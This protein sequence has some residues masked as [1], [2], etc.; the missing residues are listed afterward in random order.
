MNIREQ[1]NRDRWKPFRKTTDAVRFGHDRPSIERE[2][3]FWESTVQSKA[4]PECIKC[5]SLKAPLLFSYN[6]MYNRE[7]EDPTAEKNR[8]S[9]DP[10]VP[11]NVKIGTGADIV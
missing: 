10:A 9:A 3:S 2:D 11:E 5:S 6:N 4:S 7:D 1:S 8:R